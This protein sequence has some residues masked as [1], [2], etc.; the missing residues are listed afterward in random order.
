VYWGHSH[1]HAGLSLDAGLFGNSLGPLNAYCLA[2][3]EKITALSGIPVQLARPLDS[4]VVADYSDMMGI[5]TDPIIKPKL[6]EIPGYMLV[7]LGYTG[8]WVHENTR[9]ALFDATERKETCATTGPHMTRRLF[10]SSDFNGSNV[11][12]SDSVDIGYAKGAPVGGDSIELGWGKVS[13][14]LIKNGRY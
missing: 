8:I 14:M 3:G 10:G 6:G 7:A 1:L 4:M 9:T 13:L 12:A 2:R 11:D 5:A